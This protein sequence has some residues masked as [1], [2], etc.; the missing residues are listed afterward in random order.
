VLLAI[1]LF[2][3]L[4]TALVVNAT[5]ETM[6]AAHFQAAR[7][8]GYAAD[9]ALQAAVA[10]LAEI[11][12]WNV[13][14]AGSIRSGLSDGES[15]GAKQGP[16]VR[17]NMSE[18]INLATCGLAAGCT[19]IP[20]EASNGRRGT[21]TRWTPFLYGRLET[22]IHG[23]GRACCYVVALVG[24]DPTENDLDPGADVLKVSNPGRGALRLRVEGF[25]A[26]GARAVRL[27][28]INRRGGRTQVVSWRT[29]P[30]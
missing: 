18:V 8:A 14:L 25:G 9:A 5:A 26:H 29:G 24:N 16:G 11:A 20:A 10:E 6:I 2:G 4:A 13:V 19:E 21:T 17:L 22:L 12:D 30:S 7:G 27:A 28:T 15:S 1:S 3:A 23:G